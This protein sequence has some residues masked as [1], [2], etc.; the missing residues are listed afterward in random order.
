MK[1]DTKKVVGTNPERDA[2]IISKF[3]KEKRE[4]KEIAKD[5]GVTEVRIY[6]I[7]EN[8]AGLISVDKEYARCLRARR[9][10]KEIEGKVAS[11]KDALDWVEQYRKETE[12]TATI[13]DQKLMIQNITYDWTATET[14]DNSLLP[15]GVPAGNP[16]ITEEV[17]GGEDRPAR[18]EDGAS[19]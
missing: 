19:D 5:Y 16:R 13:I 9:C 17:S 12:G 11:R 2:E 15:A 14:K 4:V 3:W 18:R 8:N 7:L 1:I 10:E 6:Q